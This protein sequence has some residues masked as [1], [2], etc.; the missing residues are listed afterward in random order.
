[1][2]TTYVVG[3]IIGAS[4]ALAQATL[5]SPEPQLSTAERTA[6]Q[7]LES[8]KQQAQQAEFRIDQEFRI[9]HPGYYINLQTFEVSKVPTPPAPPAKK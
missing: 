2:K 7:T 6:L 9:A 1:M 8:Q 4:I 5:P 3:S